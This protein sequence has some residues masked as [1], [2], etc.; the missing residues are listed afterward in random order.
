MKKREFDELLT[1]V[2]VLTVDAYAQEMKQL[3]PNLILPTLQFEVCSPAHAELSK[4][5]RDTSVY[6]DGYGCWSW[7][8]IYH[9]S[10]YSTKKFVVA[11]S[12]N[13]KFGGLFSGKL[14]SNEV[15]L[16]FVHRDVD[17][18]SLKGFM[19]PASVTFSA[20]LG[21]AMSRDVLS[22]C[23]PAKAIVDRY[24]TSMKGDV[25]FTYNNQ[26]EVLRMSVPVDEVVSPPTDQ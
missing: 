5:W 3:F 12:S 10:K 25:A 21:L 1:G 6:K 2:G 19:I 22:V 11:V 14:S 20:F 17:C 18:P 15:E 23:E 7:E 13:G 16:Q 9:K 26:K 4:S 24:E 8:T